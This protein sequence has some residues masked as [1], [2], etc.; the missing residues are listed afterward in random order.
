[1]KR[2]LTIRF[3]STLTVAL[4]VVLLAFITHISYINNGFVWLDHGDIEQMRVIT[5][6]NSWQDIFFQRYGETGYYRPTFTLLH[7][8]NFAIFG[9]L[10]AGF[11]LTNVL[12]HT[13]VSFLAV[14]FIK[15]FLSLSGLALFVSGAIVAVHPLSWFTIGTITSAQEILM[16]FFLLISLLTYDSLR[17]GTYSKRWLLWGLWILSSMAC[18]WSK[19]T[20]VILLPG[21]LLVIEITQKPNKLS[22]SLRLLWFGV[23]AMLVFYFLL[24]TIAVPELWK[25]SGSDFSFSE[26]LGTR[27][28]SITRTFRVI[29]DPSLP[30]FYD[31]T[32]VVSATHPSSLMG[33]AIILGIVYLI[34]LLGT[35]AKL[36]RALLL[37]LLFLSPFFNIVPLPR[38]WFPNYAYALIIP[39]AAV[40][41]CILEF[42][43]KKKE[44]WYRLSLIVI[45]PLIFYM[46]LVTFQ[47]GFRFKNDETLFLAEVESEPAY[48]EGH[49]YLGTYYWQ[50][51]ILNKAKDHLDKSLQDSQNKISFVDRPAALINLAGVYSAQESTSSA[52]ALLFKVLENTTGTNKMLA[53]YN[54][55]VIYYQEK[56]YQEAERLLAKNLLQAGRPEPWLL[57]IK[58][59]LLLNRPEDA[60]AIAAQAEEKFGPKIFAL[61][62]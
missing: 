26:A 14:L 33:V 49:F 16:V 21:S 30:S 57:Y 41:G 23:A 27:F 28:A 47:A 2:F 60:Q 31:T 53:S 36:S 32:Q 11:H 13:A 35:K 51:N 61:P 50:K 17:L 25:T 5:P 29:L 39:Y 18:F 1:M 15:R 19:E 6:L 43:L 7:S 8:L 22:K 38:F 62:Y 45:A 9:L 52:K 12:L 42:L 24:R 20:A 4:L 55:A 59:L 37:S 54:L 48:R 10:P 56:N 3:T 34:F 40:V 46:V 58:T 44:V